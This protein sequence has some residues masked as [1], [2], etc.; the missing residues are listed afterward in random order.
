[1]AVIDVVAQLQRHGWEIDMPLGAAEDDLHAGPQACPPDAL[2][3]PATVRPP[4]LL[5]RLRRSR[6]ASLVRLPQFLRGY[7]SLILDRSTIGK[8]NRNLFTLE[9]ALKKVPAPDAVLLFT[10]YGTPGVSALVLATYPAAVLVSLAEL[11][12]ELKLAR[13]WSLMRFTCRWRLPQPVHSFLY[14]AVAPAELRC[15]VFPS[16]AWRDDAIRYGLNPSSAHTIYFGVPMSAMTE[17][18]VSHG[19][20]LWI[21]R[22]NPAK[23]LRLFVNA[24][25]AIRSALPEAAL[26]AIARREDDA[27]EAAI[28]EDVAGLRLGDALQ[29]VSSVERAELQ[30]AY[31]EHDMLLCVSPFSEPVPLVMM[32]AFT[33]G[34]PVV[35]SRPHAPS[36]LV[37]D[38]ETC[39]CFDPDDPRTLVEAILRLHRDAELRTR[40]TANARRLVEEQFSLDRMGAQYDSLLRRAAAEQAGA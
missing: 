5:E 24:M 28:R 17:R 18:P 39:V 10:G 1:M 36:P 8:F 2:H 35:I 30:R 7:F 22:M 16:R 33:A 37:L 20:L 32:E 15:V 34:L 29:I 3:L 25:P 14:R 21:G 23:G 4:P 19:R 9:R 12:F 27:Y 26:L 11:A 6:L 38:G 31:A 40:V 13:A